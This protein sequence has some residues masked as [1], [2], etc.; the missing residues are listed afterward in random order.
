MV[1]LWSA[2]YIVGKIAL[3]EFPPML[4]CGIRVGFATVFLAPVYIWKRWQ[5]LWTNRDWKTLLSLGIFGV[6]LNQ[7]FFMAGLGRTRASHSVLFMSGAP[8]LRVLSAP[9]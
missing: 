8:R 3:H 7:V 4:A 1:V 5:D 2:N 9:A 6:T